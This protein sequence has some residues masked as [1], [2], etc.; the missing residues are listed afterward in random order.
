MWSKHSAAV[1]VSM[2]SLPAAA[3]RVLTKFGI[4]ALNTCFVH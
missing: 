3:N 2:S 1:V 4:L